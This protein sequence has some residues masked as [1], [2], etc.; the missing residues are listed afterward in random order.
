TGSAEFRS[1][2]TVPDEGFF[3]APTILVEP[4]RTADYVRRET[5]G[6]MVSLMRVAGYEDG[7]RACTAPEFGLSASVSSASTGNA[8]RFAH[9]IQAGMVHVNSQTPGAEPNMP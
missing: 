8:I 2:G 9:D 4:D 6:P 1:V 7:V 5:F 3:A